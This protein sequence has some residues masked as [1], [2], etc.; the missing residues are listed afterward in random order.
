MV[1]SSLIHRRQIPECVFLEIIFDDPL[2]RRLLIE[3]SPRKDELFVLKIRNS[4]RSQS[5][6]DLANLA[7]S[8]WRLVWQVFVFY[9]LFILELHH[10]CAYLTSFLKRHIDFVALKTLQALIVLLELEQRLSILLASFKAE[11]AVFLCLNTFGKG[12]S[13]RLRATAVNDSLL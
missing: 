5:S 13:F 3:S 11:V 10:F 6:V 2:A 8:N 12:N 7:L 9:H 4:V 1:S